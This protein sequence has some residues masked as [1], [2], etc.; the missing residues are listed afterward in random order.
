MQD[1]GTVTGQ[2]SC[3]IEG[4]AQETE[5]IHLKLQLAFVAAEQLHLSLLSMR[6][7]VRELASDQKLTTET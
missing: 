2:V 7:I 3:R 4:E 5:L 6:E 1:T